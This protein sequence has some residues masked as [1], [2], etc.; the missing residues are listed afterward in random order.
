MTIYM[1]M[2]PRKHFISIQRCSESR[3]DMLFSYH[4]YY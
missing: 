1:K 4:S 2:S 3:S